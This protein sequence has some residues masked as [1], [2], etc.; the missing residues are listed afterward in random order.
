MSYLCHEKSGKCLYEI[1]GKDSLERYK[2]D[3]GCGQPP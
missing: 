2:R 3:N 1:A